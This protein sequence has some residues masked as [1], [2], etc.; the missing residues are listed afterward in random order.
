MKKTFLFM[1]LAAFVAFARPSLCQEA[2]DSG[3][4]PEVQ[5]KE[6]LL[7]QG[8]SPVQLQAISRG[9]ALF[10]GL[11]DASGE[12]RGAL[13]RVCGPAGIAGMDENEAAFMVLSQATRDLDEDVQVIMKEIKAMNSA[14][15]ALQGALRRFDE[16]SQNEKGRQDAAAGGE[17]GK[18]NT[19][20]NN[21]TPAANAYPAV[22]SGSKLPMEAMRT[23]HFRIE[24]WQAPPPVIREPRGMSRQEQVI[25]AGTLKAGLAALEGLLARMSA[26]VE[27]VMQRRRNFAQALE[28]MAQKMPKNGEIK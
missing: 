19:E 20:A 2:H 12:V 21:G 15:Q 25:E 1:L 26:Q 10:E 24:Y 17:K 22:A 9:A 23:A 8:L 4:S 13:D 14:R 27:R 16:L 28:G 3:A 5:R 11:P 18:Q 6:K 7:R